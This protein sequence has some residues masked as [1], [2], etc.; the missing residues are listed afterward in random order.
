MLSIN[1]YNLGNYVV[2][3]DSYGGICVDIGCNVGS[4]VSKYVH[5]FSK[6]LYYEPIKACFD[7][8]NELFSEYSHVK[9]FNNAVW[10]KSNEVVNI[11]THVNNDSGSS[12]IESDILNNEWAK[13]EIIHEV[14]TVCL[15]DILSI[16]GGEIAYCKSDCETSEYHIFLNKNIRDIKYIGMEIHWQM[17]EDKQREL[18]L[19]I[20]KTHDIIYGHVGY[21]NYNREILFKRR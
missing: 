10:S 8:C 17:G 1:K 20:L 14:Q 16:A 6:I 7:I 9:G 5:S 18:M 13:R 21:T 3:E 19:H 2:P 11:L 12:A 4:F 15:E